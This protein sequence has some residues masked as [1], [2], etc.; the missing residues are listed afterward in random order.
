M[1]V[2]DRLARM[3]HPMLFALCLTRCA[4]CA[5]ADA[6]EQHF[7]LVEDRVALLSNRGLMLVVAPGFAMLDGAAE[8]GGCGCGCG[9]AGQA[10]E[11]AG[12]LGL[13]DAALQAVHGR[14]CWHDSACLLACLLTRTIS[15][16]RRPMHAFTVRLE[17]DERMKLP[18]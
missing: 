10:G 6:Y 16:L 4:R 15:P 9:C 5:A 18:S 12:S 3:H 11:C 17:A 14:P 7:V 2:E 8:I 1:L 13:S